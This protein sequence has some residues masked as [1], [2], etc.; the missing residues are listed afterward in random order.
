MSCFVIMMIMVLSLV[1]HGAGF[2]IGLSVALFPIV[3][4]AWII[5]RMSIVWEEEGP[6]AVFS[7]GLGTL[8]AASVIYVVIMQDQIQYL[9]FY[10]PELLLV[11]LAVM[12]LLGRY[13]G[14]RLMELRRFR[15]LGQTQGKTGGE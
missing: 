5:E 3:I 9:M 8:F 1:S 12:I 11:V 15:T 10:F 14:Y 6:R 7:E 2:Q 13:T 4:L